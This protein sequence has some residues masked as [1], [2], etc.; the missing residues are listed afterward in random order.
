MATPPYK[1]IRALYDSE[2]ITVYQAYSVGIASAAVEAQKLSA[3]SKFKPTRMTWI[4][5]SWCWMMY[6]SPSSPI[7]SQLTFEAGTGVGIHTR[8]RDKPVFSHF[9]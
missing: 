3:S 4:K 8:I 7:F 1:Q 5:P 6:L 9:A 2:T